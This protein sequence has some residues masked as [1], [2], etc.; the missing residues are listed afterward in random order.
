MPLELL[1]LRC[2]IGGAVVVLF[3]DSRICGELWTWT[4]DIWHVTFTHVTAL[5]DL[6][7]ERAPGAQPA[8]VCVGGCVPAC[9]HAEV[10]RH[11]HSQVDEYFYF[12]GTE[13]TDKAQ[14]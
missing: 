2:F 13:E 11:T 10:R 6:C 4:F 3:R 14:K 1:M 7:G 5:A 9:L 8:Y 12:Q